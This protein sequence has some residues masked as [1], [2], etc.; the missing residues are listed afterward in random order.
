MLPYGNKK[1]FP[2][3]SSGDIAS[4]E[5][6][7]PITTLIEPVRTNLN[8]S[9]EV[10]KLVPPVFDYDET[11]LTTWLSNWELV[12]QTIR[13]TYYSSKNKKISIDLVAQKIEEMTGQVLSAKHM[14]FLHQNRFSYQIERTFVKLANRL[15]QRLI[16][17]TD[18]FPSYYSTGIIIR[19][20]SRNLNET[21]VNDVS[22]IWSIEHV[23]EF[24]NHIS[25]TMDINQ[26]EERLR[27]IEIISDTLVPNLKYNS[28]LTN[29]R[30]EAAA[31][32]SK[33]IIPV[34]KGQIIAKRGERISDEKSELLKR[35]AELKL[36]PSLT[37]Q[38]IVQ[39]I[40]VFLFLLTITQ[41]SITKHGFQNLS[42]R[43]AFIFMVITMLE[44][45]GIRLSLPFSDYLSKYLNLL[46]GAEFIIPV[47]TGG[48]IINLL[49]GRESAFLFAV[50]VSMLSGVYFDRGYFFGIWMLT[51]IITAIRGV[52]YCKERADL[53]RA[54]LYSGVIGAIMV[55]GYVIIQ[56]L[57]LQGIS[58]TRLMAC[59]FLSVLSGIISMAFTSAIIPALETWV[60]YTTN[61]KLLEL[62]NFNHPLLQKLMMKAPVT[63]HHSIT[64]GSLAEI[65]AE[66]IGA[67]GQL[68]KVGAFYHD[69]GKMENPMY[70]YEN[71]SPDYNPHDQ[72]TPSMSAKILFS[73][74]KNGVQLA[75]EYKL[76]KIITDII[77][78]HHGTTLVPYFLDKAKK[79]LNSK[80]E[81]LESEYRYPGPL[82]STREA[83][84]V[85]LADACEA[86]VRSIVSP[87]PSKISAMVHHIIFQRLMD[88]QLN[89]CDLSLNDLKIAEE[90][91]SKTLISLNHH[92]IEYPNQKKVVEE[93]GEKL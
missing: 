8:S 32:I 18:L 30:I 64:V 69:I 14:L 9:E 12:F 36:F 24:L 83:G 42:S 85:M 72:L 90:C 71:Q 52:K 34:K 39:F 27:L 10:S 89:N 40:V 51:S 7:V 25:A 20:I 80:E 65:A 6:V 55:V 58:L 56:S 50:I 59:A 13:N 75:E 93:S 84:I 47:A 41:L 88:N 57:G 92:R 77:E 67:N 35:I 43:D 87:S 60:G 33:T 48:M 81:P 1:H 91:F 74:V 17:S 28:A 76:G 82:P 66:K 62:A 37:K 21:Y 53:Y 78:E 61:L 5:I 46:Y 63:Y 86:A 4:T 2:T 16:A 31:G 73:H 15:T 11:A 44:L 38:T 22:K 49:M 29:K 26:K 3:L 23:K 54:G 70:F 79:L 68:A 19:Q 45:A